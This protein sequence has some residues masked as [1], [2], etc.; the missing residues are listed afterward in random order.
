[1]KFF[2][3]PLSRFPLT[4]ISDYRSM[5]QKR[6][7]IQLFD[8]LEGGAFDEVTMQKN[9]T[10]FQHIQLKRRV[11]KDVS[12]ITMETE[13]LGQKIDFPLI[14]APIG[15]AGVYARRGEVQAA[16]AAAKA[17]IPFSLSTV[18][19]CSIE[20]VAQNCANPFW[21]QFYLFKDREHS[22]EL[23]QRAQAAF[24]PVL[25]LTVDL[26]MSGARHRY[27]RGR[28]NS[29]ISYFLDT[30]VHF[31]WLIDVRLRGKPLTIGNI[32][33]SAPSLSD[34]SSMRRWMGN[35]LNLNCSWKDF[36]WL[37]THWNGKIVVK[38]ILDPEDATM[39]HNLGA[40][41]IVVSNHGGRHLDGTLSTIGALPSI[42][43]AV[44]GRL[45]ILIDGGITSGLDIVKALSVGADACMIGKSWMYGLAARGEKGVSEI[46]AIL[47]NEI[48]IVMS[49]LG[50]SSIDEI[51]SDLL[52]L[53][54]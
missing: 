6:L 2:D 30:L 27:H 9:K 54:Q 48:K 38:G 35:Q 33:H 4:A 43:D 32:P 50:V 49:H 42:C 36:E 34:L 20:E 29:R 10:D 18:G 3:Q 24:C 26:P 11:L 37:R 5:A 51:H 8:F 7:P 28:K 1:M 13:I 12:T 41:G 21:F 45:Q 31:P 14:L 25:L 22:L 16:K 39:A 46:L 52:V 40:D 53:K 44:K 15:F 17:N 47:K 23:L 19:I